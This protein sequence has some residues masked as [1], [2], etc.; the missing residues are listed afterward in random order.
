MKKLLAFL[1][2]FGFSYGSEAGISRLDPEDIRTI[3]AV[4]LDASPVVNN[5]ELLASKVD[6]SFKIDLV[7]KSIIQDRIRIFK[8]KGLK[9]ISFYLS[10]G[11][12]YIPLIK[13]IFD[14]HGIP[15]ELIFLPI[16]ESHFNIK[17]KSPAGA[18]GLW[19]FMPQ[20]ARMY[21]L[22]I[23]KWIDERYDVEKSTTAAALYLKDLYGIFED[24]SLALASYNTG[25]GV[26]IRKINKYG[27][28]NFWDI[29][30]YLSRE[31][32]N[33]VPNFLATV[34]VVR[35][36]LEK[37]HF[38]YLHSEFDILRVNRPVSLRYIASL[39]GVPL[40]TLKELNPHLKKGV[41][42]PVE[43]QFNLYIPKG[44]K[45]TLK[46]ALEKSPVEKYPAFVEYTVKKGDS[47][48]KIAK[49]YGTTVSYLKK[50]NDLENTVI[51]AGSVLKV[52]SYIKALPDYYDGVIDLTED[53]IYTPKGVIYKVKKGD[54]LSKIAKKFRV[55]VSALKR[56]NK[57]DGFIYPNQRIVIYR[58]IKHRNI[59]SSA[60]VKRNI[61]YLKRKVKK[62]KPTFRYIHYK[63]KSGDSLIK[64]A[65]KYGVSVQQIKKWNKLNSSI[66]RV[67]QKITI[68]KR[69]NDG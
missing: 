17:A 11:K 56:W 64:I 54:T 9:R 12:K 31:T 69:V 48:A 7:E 32:R 40:E 37:E 44:Y 53:V 35:E 8:K 49:K 43:G 59:G 13:E 18:A 28:L 19:Q 15:D 42:P 10:R 61:N 1:L 51:V 46:I 27:G 34:A 16:I 4:A 67:G 62:R 2:A 14:R 30:E 50:I 33:Y 3:L 20:T 26:I 6:I 25:E 58:K 41:I 52:P 22:T 57:I 23:N 63:V 66:I 45:E 68:I 39:I 47:L 21:G 55:S 65:K 24:W 36:L 5:V 38:D 29:D 60:V